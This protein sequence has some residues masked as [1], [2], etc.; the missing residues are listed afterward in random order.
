MKPFSGTM[1]KMENACLVGRRSRVRV[2]LGPV[3]NVIIIIP[4]LLEIRKRTDRIV[5]ISSILAQ[6]TVKLLVIMIIFLVI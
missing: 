4:C 1:A 2:S 6:N 3:R 5:K